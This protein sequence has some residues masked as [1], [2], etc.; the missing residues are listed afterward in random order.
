MQQL[1][2]KPTLAADE[3]DS[4]TVAGGFGCGAPTRA[5]SAALLAALKFCGAA[6]ASRPFNATPR[7]LSAS[8]GGEWKYYCRPLEW[9]SLADMSL[10]KGANNE[11]QQRPTVLNGRGDCV[12]VSLSQHSKW[13]N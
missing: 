11:T 1:V 5:R 13:L 9:S 7:L 8:E 12:R 3:D 2:Y 10:A 4:I 6:S